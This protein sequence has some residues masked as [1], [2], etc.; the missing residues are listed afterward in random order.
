MESGLWC[1]PSGAVR[2]SELRA[3]V[4]HVDHSAGSRVLCGINNKLECNFDFVSNVFAADLVLAE[5]KSATLLGGGRALAP[6][7][8]ANTVSAMLASRIAQS[9]TQD[10]VL[11]AGELSA[12]SAAVRVLGARDANIGHV[13]GAVRRAY[14]AANVME[15]LVA[16]GVPERTPLLAVATLVHLAGST[17]VSIGLVAVGSVIAETT[18]VRA[19]LPADG[20]DS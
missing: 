14:A 2:E 16:L 11:V 18:I 15:A 1:S 20:T 5:A 7:D 13:L 6:A 8:G 3:D 17:T 10:L 19:V 4:C 12:S 9:S